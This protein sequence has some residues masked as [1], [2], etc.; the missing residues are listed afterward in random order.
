[1][2]LDQE[3]IPEPAEISI[4]VQD[5]M[6]KTMGITSNTQNSKNKLEPFNFLDQKPQK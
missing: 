4:G 3:E 5:H 1:M 2:V 6:S